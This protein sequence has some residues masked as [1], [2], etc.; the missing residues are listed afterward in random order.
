MLGIRSVRI[1]PKDGKLPCSGFTE[2]MTAV[3]CRL[4]P[5]LNRRTNAYPTNDPI[6]IMTKKVTNSLN[7]TL[8]RPDKLSVWEKQVTIEKKTIGTAHILS[9]FINKVQNG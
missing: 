3:R 8:L 4:L 1:F 5:V 6:S 2:L 9:P 7:P